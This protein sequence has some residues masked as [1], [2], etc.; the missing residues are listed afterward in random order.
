MEV[1]LQNPSTSVNQCGDYCVIVNAIAPA[2]IDDNG[3]KNN[4]I[5]FTEHKTLESAV[6]IALSLKSMIPAGSRVYV[7]HNESIFTY[8][9]A[10]TC[11][12]DF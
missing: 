10:Y 6:G 3:C 12:F 9:T 7:V 8:L 11:V 1:N 4:S 2:I 5:V